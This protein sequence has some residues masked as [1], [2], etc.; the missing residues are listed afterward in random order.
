MMAEEMSVSPTTNYNLSY[1]FYI[2]NSHLVYSALSWSDIYIWII[3]TYKWWSSELLLFTIIYLILLLLLLDFSLL[4]ILL[5]YTDLV[6]QYDQFI[7]CFSQTTL[8]FGNLYLSFVVSLL[9]WSHHFEHLIIFIQR[10]YPFTKTFSSTTSFFYSFDIKHSC[11]RYIRLPDFIYND[12]RNI[13]SIIGNQLFQEIFLRHELL[14]CFPI[15]WYFLILTYW[16]HDWWNL[17]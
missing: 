4:I 16:H 5:K 15:W 10:Q 6:I 14:G 13:V 11:V 2:I 8:Q 3:H 9:L 1:N 17:T 12:I 7:T